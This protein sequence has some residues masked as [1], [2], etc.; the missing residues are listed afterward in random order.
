MLTDFVVLGLFDDEI[1]EFICEDTWIGPT[2]YDPC[3]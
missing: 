1:G 2:S 3:S